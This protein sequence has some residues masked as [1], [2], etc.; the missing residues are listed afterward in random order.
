MRYACSVE[1]S[2]SLQKLPPDINSD[3][4]EPRFEQARQVNMEDRVRRQRE[5]EEEE[6]RKLEEEE[7]RWREETMRKLAEVQRQREKKGRGEKKEEIEKN[8]AVEVLVS[9]DGYKLIN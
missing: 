3:H 8:S 9:R 7:R 1:P 4:F 6:R 2:Q 5:E